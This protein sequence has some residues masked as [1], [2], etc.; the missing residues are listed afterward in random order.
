VTK[1]QRKIEVSDKFVE[2]LL[3]NTDIT[4]RRVLWH[5]RPN[6]KPE[7]DRWE[8]KNVVRIPKLDDANW[9]GTPKSTNAQLILTEGDSAKMAISGLFRRRQRQVRRFPLRGK[10]LNVRVCSLDVSPITR[11][12]PTSKKILGLE[13]IRG[14]HRST[15]FVTEK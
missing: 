8:K 9:A 4:K 13:N 14:T 15:N 5:Q 1:F 2:D 12:S 10:L 6:R 3:K 11:K 7:E